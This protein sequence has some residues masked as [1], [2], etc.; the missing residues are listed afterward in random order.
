MLKDQDR[1]F[2][3]IYGIKGQGLGFAKS[4][5]DWSNTAELVQKGRD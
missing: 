2:Q 4:I 3:N 5:G 1:I